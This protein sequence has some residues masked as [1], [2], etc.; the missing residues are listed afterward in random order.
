MLTVC[1]QNR[2]RSTNAAVIGICQSKLDASVLIIII[3]INKKLV[4]IIIKFCV[5]IKTDLLEE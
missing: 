3:E 2:G 5:W 4:L 1:Y